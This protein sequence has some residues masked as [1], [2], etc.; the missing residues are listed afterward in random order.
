MI[1]VLALLGAAAAPA[2]TAPEPSGQDGRR[3][4]GRLFVSPMGEPFRGGDHPEQAWFAGADANHDQQISRSEFIAD[5]MRFF[6]TLD[7][8]H[9]REIGPTE[10]DRYEQ[11]LLPESAGGGGG[12]LGPTGTMRRPD[13]G[14]RGGMGRGGGAMRGGPPGEG[15]EGRGPAGGT[16]NAGYVYRASG[17]GRFGYIA[18]PEPVTAAD[19]DLN[20]SVTEREFVEAAGRRFA[21][22]D[23]NGDGVITPREL[24]KLSAPRFRGRRVGGDAAPR[25][26]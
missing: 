19:A 7:M 8:N 14:R 12:G 2:Q 3:Q 23:T 18:T 13:G 1:A 26:E 10:I 21:L 25:P 6:A 17:A 4:P 11:E 15:M 24:P 5:A 16:G 20:R 22:L 9:D